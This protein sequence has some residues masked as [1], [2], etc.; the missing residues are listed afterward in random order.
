MFRRIR[1]AQGNGRDQTPPAAVQA[2]SAGA[3]YQ[4][5][6]PDEPTPNIPAAPQ[7]TS[8]KDTSKRFATPGPDISAEVSNEA[9]RRKRLLDLRVHMHTKLL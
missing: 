6:R 8:V 1:D 7:P 5:P 2:G 3:A 9:R 4:D